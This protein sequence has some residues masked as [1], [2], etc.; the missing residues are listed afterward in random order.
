MGLD[1]DGR[2][3]R[4]RLNLAAP[5]ERV[6]RA[7]ATA[8]GRA[9]F[10]ALSAPEQDDIITFRFGSGQVVE[11]RIL[12]RSLP[13][14]FVL[15]YFGGSR[16]AFDLRPDGRGGTDLTL[17]ETG[18]PESEIFDNLPGWVSVL[19]NLKAAVDF[20]VDLRNGDPTRQWEQGYVDV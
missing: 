16:V 11:S 15:T 13:D 4:W 12:E 6:H 20:G 10:W 2:T 3:I 1:A 5:P 8:E 14:R 19:L 7:L 9:R 17:V 18:V